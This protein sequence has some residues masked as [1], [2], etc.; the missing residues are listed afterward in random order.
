VTALVGTA[1]SA[2][3][4]STSS[5]GNPGMYTSGTCASGFPTFYPGSRLVYSLYLGDDAPLGGTLT[6]TMC[7]ATADNTVLYVGTGCPTASYSFGCLAGV[8]DGV[9][10][11]CASNGLASTL[12]IAASQRSYFLQVGGVNGRDV[13]TGLSWVY[14]APPASASRTR[15]PSRSRTRSRSRSRSAS[16]TGTRSRTRKPKR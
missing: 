1:G 16:R 3:R 4:L 8:D 7:G 9:A 5:Y 15:T 10:P 12:K 13:T 14:A 2:P 11:P 6:V